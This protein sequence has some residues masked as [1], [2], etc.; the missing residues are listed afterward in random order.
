MQGEQCSHHPAA[1]DVT[2][3]AAENPE[4]QQRIDNVQGDVDVVRAGGVVAEDLPVER[5]GHPRHRMPVGCI[6]RGQRPLHSLPM[7]AGFDVHVVGDVI[8]IVVIGERLPVYGVVDG[9]D[10]DDQHETE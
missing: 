6:A 4:Q 10:R 9:G 8:G 2:G 7:Q 1:T 3:C 5:M